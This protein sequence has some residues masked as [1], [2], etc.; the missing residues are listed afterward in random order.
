MCTRIFWSGNRVG[1][2]VARTM[3]WAVSDEPVLWAV[4]PGTQRGGGDLAWRSRLGVLALSMWGAGTTDGLNTAGLAAHLLYLGSASFA[5]PGSPGAIPNLLWAQ[6]VLDQFETVA[7]AVAA[8]RNHCVTSVPARN[9]ELGCHLVLED[10]SGDSAIVEPAGETLR[11]YH[12]REYRVVAND[13]PFAEQLA[14][15]RSYRP[16]GGDAPVPGTIE[17]PDRFV[18]ASYY[19]HHL[20]E[21]ADAAEAVAGVAAVAGTV[22]VPPGAPYDD[23]SVYPTWWM[24]AADFASLTYYF[25][26]RTSPAAIWVELP[27]AGLVP[28]APVRSV[29]PG[30]PGLAGEVSG[31]LRPARLCY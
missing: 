14:N 4:P 3:D 21:P 26:S 29:D 2:V 6:W 22:S 9:Q 23:F 28:G 16:F 18:R 12:S 31:H 11:I 27:G 24:S 25:W 10:A 30:E 5:P 15:L 7:G 8:L 20:P 19:L 1:P 13:P 17:S